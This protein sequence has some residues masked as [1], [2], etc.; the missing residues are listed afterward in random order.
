MPTLGA[1]LDLAKYEARN[2]RAHILG[3]A[4][5]S[6][7][8]GQLYFNSGDNTLY[9]W[10]GTT[11]VAAQSGASVG[12]A[13]TGTKGVIQLAGDLTGTA[14]SPQIAAGAIVDAD[15][16]NGAAIAES[17]LSLASDAAAGTPSR[18][19]LGSGATQAAPGNDARFSD[20]RAP[21]GAAGG[22]LAGSTYPNPVIA[23]GVVTSA[24]I[25]DGTITDTDVAP[26]NKDG[27]AGTASMRSLGN[28]AQQAL[29]GTT[30]LNLISPPAADVSLNS[31]KITTLA[32]PTAAQDAA[33]KNYV[34]L[35]AQGIDAKQSVLCASTGNLGLS[36][37]AAV[38]GITPSANDR[39]LVKNQASQPQNGVYA[40]S[41]G[42]W[43]RVTDMDTWAE[44]PGA[45]VFVER[46]ASGQEDTGWICTADQGGTLGTTPITWAQFSGAG[47]IIDGIG[48]LKTGNTLDVRLDNSTIEAPG[49]VLQVKASGITGTHLAPG[50]VDL[51]STD[52]TGTLG[53]GNGGT[54]QTTAK[55]AR[56]TGLGAA[57][58]YHNNATHG[59]GTTITIAQATH[60]LR[61][62]RAI[63]VQVQD[64]ATG[65]VEIPDISVAAN[66]DV[67]VTYGASVGANTKLV[68]LVG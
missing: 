12:D 58:I 16:N 21:T 47:Q 41:A 32:D 43:T 60:G 23:N 8:T 31:K 59:A 56:E 49:D 15:V 68:S 40:A 48:L 42:S 5:S 54:G 18:R 34:D 28:G 55:A 26:A 36:G 22:D 4:P 39:I 61:A 10:N 37:L 7:V 46:S 45:F 50:S 11:W 38:D 17:K 20:A 63:H 2:F 27:V 65:N 9:W 25:A 24:K 30:P 66:G 44:H 1:P 53:L 6:P 64:N 29:S 67:T 13:T 19:S 33:T 51:A 52:V 35:T 3:A 14:T 62:S 57:G